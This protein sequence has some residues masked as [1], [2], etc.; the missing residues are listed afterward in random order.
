MPTTQTNA[1]RDLSKLKELFDNSWGTPVTAAEGAPWLE[2]LGAKIYGSN[3]AK[4][5]A[6]D[7]MSKMPENSWT[8]EN[9]AAY[10]RHMQ[11]GAKSPF[12]TVSDS[13]IELT[14]EDGKTSNI[15]MNPL[16]TT[17]Q[18]AATDFKAHPGKY[19][20]TALNTGGA[21]AGLLD[22]DK[23]GGQLVTTAAGAVIPKL[24]GMKLGPLAAYNVAV[25]AGHLGSLFDNLRA[26]KEREQAQQQ[27]YGG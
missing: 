18:I 25:G 11:R 10:Q 17:G 6:F 3:A 12:S 24:L 26:K 8:P 1:K 13:V 27:Y 7:L 16:S 19:L 5:N 4:Q 15:N 22:N 21:I 14:K 23:F 2:N 9:L 20:G